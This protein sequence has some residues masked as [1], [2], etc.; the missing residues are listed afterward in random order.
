[1]AALQREESVGARG[2]THGIHQQADVRLG[3]RR[4]TE[5]QLYEVQLT[6]GVRLGGL[7]APTTACL[8]RELAVPTHSGS[9]RLELGSLKRSL[10]RVV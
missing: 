4:W 10:K 8:Q 5:R 2:L 1:V 9:P 6:P 3:Q 7:A